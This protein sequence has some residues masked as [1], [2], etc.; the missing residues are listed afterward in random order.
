MDRALDTLCIECRVMPTNI[1]T[2][3]M[4]FEMEGLCKDLCGD[5]ADQVVVEHPDG[6]TMGLTEAAL[7]TIHRILVSLLWEPSCNPILLSL[8]TAKTVNSMPLVSAGRAQFVNTCEFTRTCT[9]T[10]RQRVQSFREASTSRTVAVTRSATFCH[11][12]P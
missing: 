5:D 3:L 8:R 6:D 2:F 9:R 12:L 7:D 10:C 4:L 11:V 1:L